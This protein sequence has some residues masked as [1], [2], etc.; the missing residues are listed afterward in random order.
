MS[1]RLTFKVNN[2]FMFMAVHPHL[3]GAVR[4]QLVLGGQVEN[5][6]P[7]VARGAL[8]EEFLVHGRGLDVDHTRSDLVFVVVRCQ[9]CLFG[10][11]HVL[12]GDFNVERSA[13]CWGSRGRSC[14]CNCRGG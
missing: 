10:L 6:A 12:F 8:A 2:R 3:H 7:S 1:L 13:R 14:R 11:V 5:L 4:G 9:A